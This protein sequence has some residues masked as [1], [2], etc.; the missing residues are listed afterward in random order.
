MHHRVMSHHIR[1]TILYYNIHY[2]IPRSVVVEYV[3]LLVPDA[4]VGGQVAL[5]RLRHS[6]YIYS[7]DIY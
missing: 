5:E 2:T 1:N 4:P 7:V 6:A 3:P